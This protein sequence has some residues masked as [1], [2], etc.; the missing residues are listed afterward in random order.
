LG[1]QYL[2]EL[3][4]LAAIEANNAKRKTIFPEDLE[5]ASRKLLTSKANENVSEENTHPPTAPNIA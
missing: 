4:R 5:S 2:F 1:H 3:G